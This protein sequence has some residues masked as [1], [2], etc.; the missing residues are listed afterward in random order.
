VCGVE[1]GTTHD[2]TIRSIVGCAIFEKWSPVVIKKE[3][4]S[5]SFGRTI[6]V[7]A[8]ELDNELVLKYQCPQTHYLVVKTNVNV[9]S[10]REGSRLD[11][12]SS[13]ESSHGFYMAMWTLFFPILSGWYLYHFMMCCKC[14]VERSH[15]VC[16]EK[17]ESC[18]CYCYL[19]ERYACCHLG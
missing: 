5:K 17:V 19:V 12:V 11:F 6:E 4:V 18:V 3:R 14:N 2:M 1:L 10:P 7:I 13:L 9:Y 8:N 15:T 16:C